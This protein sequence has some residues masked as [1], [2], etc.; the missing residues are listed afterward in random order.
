MPAIANL[1]RENREWQ[2]PNLMQLN[3][4]RGMRLMDESLA[5]LVRAKKIAVEQAHL[6]ATD[7]TRFLT[8]V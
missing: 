6:R 1:I 4:A 5:E 7:K 3:R 8:P 2:I